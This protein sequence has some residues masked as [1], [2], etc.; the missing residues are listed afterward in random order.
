MTSGVRCVYNRK[1]QN[2]NRMNSFRYP[3]TVNSIKGQEFSRI[4]PMPRKFKRKHDYWRV[5]I[6]YTNSE[7]SA[8]RV[9]NIPQVY[10][11]LQML[12]NQFAP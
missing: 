4:L 5:V 1:R 7:T 11:Q 3:G 8:N 2:L 6:V 9:A 12:L 10:V